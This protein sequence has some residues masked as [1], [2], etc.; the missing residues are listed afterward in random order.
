MRY[1]WGQGVVKENQISLYSLVAE[2]ANLQMRGLFMINNNQ[3][4]T[5]IN[6]LQLDITCVCYQC[7][8]IIITDISTL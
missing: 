4:I 5:N 3:A 6:D 7:V 8:E 1:F 2:G